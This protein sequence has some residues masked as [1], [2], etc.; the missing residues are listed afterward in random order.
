MIFTVILGVIGGTLLDVSNYAHYAIM[1][2]M[3]QAAPTLGLLLVCV[4][5]RDF[6]AFK[7]MNR[8]ISRKKII[9]ILPA[10]LIPVI[11]IGGSALVLSFTGMPYVKGAYNSAGA[12]SVIIIATIIGA[13]GEE[14]GWRGFMFPVLHK[15]HNL[16]TSAVVTGLLWGLWHF[17]KIQLSGVTGYLLFTLLCVEFTVLMAWIL[18]KAN[19][20]LIPMIV[21]HTV[22]NTCSVLLINEREGFSFYAAACIIGGVLCCLIIMLNRT[23]FFSQID[24]KSSDNRT[25]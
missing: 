5:G 19:N 11:F 1:L 16:F 2:A 24:N 25:D 3:A 12:L 9:W 18:K 15:K 17:G 23:A 13:T 20:S 10:V 7:E 14:I 21:F 4:F 22:I 8:S 6:N